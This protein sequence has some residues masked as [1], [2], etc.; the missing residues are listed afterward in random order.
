MSI[1][2]TIARKPAREGVFGVIRLDYD[3][4]WYNDDGTYVEKLSRPSRNGAAMSVRGLPATARFPI[5]GGAET[6]TLYEPLERWMYSLC[7]GNDPVSWRSLLSG[8][9]K[10][11][12]FFSDFAGTETNHS[13]VLGT[14][15]DAEPIKVKPMGC[16]GTIIKII[17]ERNIGREA[18]WVFEAV[19]PFEDF[20]KIQDKFWLFFRPTNS[21]RIA[22][23]DAKGY[24]VRWLEYISEPFHQ[25]DNR[26][27]LPIFAQSGR[28]NYIQKSRVRVLSSTEPLPSPYLNSV[29]TGFESHFYPNP[30]K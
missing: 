23:K 4:R 11:A 1:S 22:T 14:N 24:F 28:E 30:Y 19:N 26:T 15:P 16:G 5:V 9:G 29:V 20:T 21:V 13:F 8:S 3:Q 7:G 2:I 27:L 6:V 18:G 12:R 25:F 17:G 10:S